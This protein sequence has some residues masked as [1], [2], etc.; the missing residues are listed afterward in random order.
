MED[1]LKELEARREKA[2]LGGGQKRIES[3]HSKGKLTARERINLLLDEKSFEEYDM[4]VE[5]DS[6]EFGMEKNK[7]PGDGVVIGSGEINGRTVFLYVKDFTVFGGSL[8]LAHS[9]K[10]NKIQDMAVKNNAPLIGVL[11]AGG[12]RIQEGIDALGGYAEVFQ[13]NVL[14][15]GVIPQISLV[16]G[17]CA[18]GD[19][20]SPALT[21]FIFMVRD[22]S[23]M[24]VTGPD[25]VKTVTNEEVTADQLGGA[26]V[27]TTISSV[28]DGAYDNDLE[29]ISE[30]RR[31]IDFLPSSNISEGP[32]RETSDSIKR[33]EPSL[34]TLIP[35]SSNSPYDIKE[36]ITK[37]VDEDD[38]F[39]IQE[40]F[41]QNIVV[42]FGRVDGHTVG[43]IGNQPLFL[44]GV[45]DSDASRKG[46][47]FVRFCDAFSIPLVTFVDVPGFL[48]GTDQE[49]GGLIKNGAKLL[50]AYAE[51]TVPKVTVITRKAYGGA[52]CVMAPKHLR[53]DINYALPSAE[54]AVMG[55]KG[56][57]E[58]L[59]RKDIE[60]TK[61][62]QEHTEFYEDRLLNPFVAAERG[63][64]D[65]VIMPRNIRPRIG[66][67]LK[68]LRNKKLSNPWKKHDN[69]PL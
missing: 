10:I 32:I 46:A 64:I 20:Y 14:A 29:M 26:E 21:D 62:I 63:Y 48:P 28:A 39:E 13:R 17:P 69:L 34:D 25:V 58:I 27:H 42:G 54:I 45:L 60:D 61:K 1:I 41:A 52:Y 68:L 3:Q 65:D 11:D 16:M 18:G 23:Y 24:F 55:A 35:E 4:F 47:R 49:Y 50:Y 31:F 57:V 5:H 33:S 44:A 30:M 2:K 9:R 12:A 43:L 8:S 38:F 37:V 40:N 53:G 19:V 67:A 56:A 15:S 6:H 51:A 59:Y 22:T 36:F 66:K 7:I